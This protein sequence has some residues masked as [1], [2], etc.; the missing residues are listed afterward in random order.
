MLRTV[1]AVC[2][3]AL[4]AACAQLPRAEFQA[5]RDSFQ[6]AQTAADPLIAD[7]GVAERA[8]LVQR[9]RQDPQRTFARF[10]Y[11]SDLQPDRDAVALSP[12]VQP[13]GAT[14][15]NR[16]F[17]GIALYNESLVALAENKNI[18]VAKAQLNQLSGNVTALV[19]GLA[20]AQTTITQGISALTALL[21]PLVQAEN[22]EQFRQAVI[23]GHPHVEELINALR[24]HAAP[25][26]GTRVAGLLEELQN[27][28]DEG[29]RRRLIAEINGWHAAYANYVAL[30]DV[31][32]ARLSDLKEAVENPRSAPLLERA[33]QGSADVRAHAETLRRTIAEIRVQRAPGPTG[34]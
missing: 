5:Y 7:Y 34:P 30:L 11:F 23:N 33:V 24:D 16:I 6:A 19:P 13:P 27:E 28:A 26:F 9:I 15:L 22:R 2:L 29:D 14:A 32:K 1:F 4:S 25:Q 12:F 10:G 21:G 18:D 31:M 17:Q 3:L 20:G 8:L